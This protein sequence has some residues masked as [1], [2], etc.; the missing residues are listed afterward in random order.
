M[1]SITIRINYRNKNRNSSRKH[2]RTSSRTR[3]CSSSRNRIWS[4]YI[5]NPNILE[6]TIVTHLHY[7]TRTSYIAISYHILYARFHVS[8]PTYHIPHT[9]CCLQ[10][11]TS[12]WTILAPSCPT[13]NCCV[14]QILYWGLDQIKHQ[15]ASKLLKCTKMTW[16]I[17][18]PS[19]TPGA[20]WYL[21]CSL[22]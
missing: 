10:A 1:T 12:C 15:R 9:I 11:Q 22:N 6:H 3:S 20:F 13:S 17:R 16:C 7:G 21:L 19:K 14:E 18:W 4:Y 2:N 5:R 8:Y